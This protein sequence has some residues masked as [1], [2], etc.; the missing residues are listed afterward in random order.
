MGHEFVLCKL[1][2]LPIPTRPHDNQHGF[3]L[4]ISPIL[5]M[6]AHAVKGALK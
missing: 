1:V 4:I 5:P 6:Y 2:F 3:G